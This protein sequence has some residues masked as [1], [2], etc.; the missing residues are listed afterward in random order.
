MRRI[1]PTL[2]AMLLFNFVAT[3]QDFPY[4]KVDNDALAMKKY[5]KDTSAHAVVINEYGSSHMGFDN[6]YR[7][8]IT[9]MRHVKIKFFDNK[10]F[11]NSGTIVEELYNAN[12]TS[13]EDITDVKAVTFY[14][15]DNGNIQQAELDKSKIFRTRDSKHVSSVKFVL[16]ALRSGCVVEF[17]YKI[18]SPY[19]FNFKGWEFQSS[20]PKM[21]SVYE[22]HIPGFW[23]YN[24]ALAGP[25][26]LSFNT[27][28]VERACFTYGGG[29][30]VSGGASADCS[31]IVYGMTDVPAFV[32]EEY[33]TSSKNFKSAILYQLVQET[34]LLSGAKSKYAKEW[35]DIDYFLKTYSEFGTQLKRTS[36]LKDRIS[37]VIAGKTDELTKAKAV[38]SYINS[39]I[40]WNHRESVLS[41]DGLKQALENHAGTS[42]DI[43][44]NLV[45]ALNAAGIPTEAVIISTRDHGIVNKLYPDLNSFNYVIA[46]ANIGGQSYLLDGTDPLLPFGML[47]LRCLNDQGRVFSMDKPSYWI[48]MT[49]GQRE[50]TTTTVDLTLQSDG[51]LKGTVTRFSVGYSAYLKR[52]EIKKSNSL[53]EYLEHISAEN[54]NIKVIKS[55]VSNIDS[56]DNPIIETLEVEVNPSDKM[57]DNRI[58][59]SPFLLNQIK[60]NPF[61]LAQRDYPVDRG[62]PSE[63]RYII[64]VHLPAEYTLENTTQPIAYGLPNQGGSFLTDFSADANTFTYSYITRINHSVFSPE[65]YPYLKELYNKIILAEKNELVFKKK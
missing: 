64:T 14:K 62:M 55:Q 17:S 56:I 1:L 2:I 23:E 32:E 51:K 65:E 29:G 41:S 4:G 20:I 16:P 19:T 21:R 54:H 13:Y 33:M 43:N 24:A 47:P 5:D 8:L 27:A 11:E 52:A 30:G 53:D 61:K 63:D 12:E 44:L 60:I 3:A 35:K 9:F 37:P 6:D 18:T 25:L 7:I 34:D 36:L 28:K 22:V 38:Y 42:G 31:D 46:K 57:T 10:E 49:T 58:G 39:T 48:D 40:K 45:T 59:F 26:K 15:D 50:K